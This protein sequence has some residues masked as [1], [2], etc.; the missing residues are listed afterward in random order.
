MYEIVFQS[1][2]P[3][4][5]VIWGNLLF[6]IL[7]FSGLLVFNYLL[8]Q[9]QTSMRDFFEKDMESPPAAVFLPLRGVTPEIRLTLKSLMEQD[10]PDYRVF[11]IL[12]HVEDSGYTTVRDI[13]AE[14]DPEEKIIELHVR[15][16]YY[17]TASPKTSSLIEYFR[18]TDS[19]FINYVLLDGDVV[20]YPMWLRDVTIPL[21]DP[22]VK[23]VSGYRW[24]PPVTYSIAENV[25]YLFNAVSWVWICFG[26]YLWGGSCSFSRDIALSDTVINTL[27]VSIAE[28]SGLTAVM[29]REHWKTFAVP[30]VIS[31]NQ[32][33]THNLFSVFNWLRRQVMWNYLSLP[34]N[35]FF[36]NLMVWAIVLCQLWLLC[37]GGLSL[38]NQNWLLLKYVLA[39]EGIFWCGLVLMLAILEIIA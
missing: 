19:R 9:N 34:R 27:K 5:F 33:E 11:V 24:Y 26:K 7:S 18:K 10:Y 2:W 32:E 35:W 6:I 38:Y 15:S 8:H 13:L 21:S 23:A 29:Q 1:E 37:V 14:I 3:L 36:Y 39:C 28:D 4:L 20:P 16:E 22:T 31:V 17:E 12:D 25:R 30:S